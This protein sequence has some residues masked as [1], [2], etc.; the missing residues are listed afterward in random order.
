[1]RLIRT[2]ENY[3][4]KIVPRVEL[5]QRIAEK[6]PES[7]NEISIS[8]AREI[9]LLGARFENVNPAKW[10][11]V[12]KGGQ[13][14]QLGQ[15]VGSISTSGLNLIISPKVDEVGRSG[16]R[17]ANGCVDISVLIRSARTTA[18]PTEEF[19][20]PGVMDIEVFFLHAERFIKDLSREVVFGLRCG[21]VSAAEDLKSLRGRL[22][23]DKLP[24][25][26]AISPE[27]IPCKFEE[28]EE[29]T[30]H[31]QVLRRGVVIIRSMLVSCELDKRS[32]P[33]I[34]SCDDLLGLLSRVSDVP[35]SWSDVVG[36]EIGR[37]EARYKDIFRYAK[38]LI[39]C[40]APIDQGASTSSEIPSF[41]SGFSQVWDAAILY[42]RHIANYLDDKL[43]H[44]QK[45]KRKIRYKLMTQ[46]ECARKL[47]KAA[48][49]EMGFYEI[50]PD[51]VIW[52]DVEKRAHL[53]ID[54]KWKKHDGTMSDAR[55]AD[56]YQVHAYSTTYS[57]RYKTPSGQP[58]T[59][60]PPVCLLYPV[61]GQPSVPVVGEFTGTGSKFLLA[62]APMDQE[63][64]EFDPSIIL[65]EYWPL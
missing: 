49:G 52:D 47:V 42:E 50:L 27:L 62:S 61:I 64:F 4:L 32:R 33:L 51:I 43:K 56:A 44:G 2:F 5:E 24:L 29:N 12:V 31:N 55:Q 38:L 3:R 11:R 40:A 16:R 36:L 10:A 17:N 7:A 39:K 58:K 20:D 14:L 1:M 8:D 15:Y 57:K 48:D 60:Y 28:F 30:L 6:L 63:N 41:Q 45:R 23:V 21:Y 18:L 65:G 9:E 46:Q 25:T 26:N 19:A 34:D 53:I 13:Y 59:Y 37:L 22:D 54:T 35:L